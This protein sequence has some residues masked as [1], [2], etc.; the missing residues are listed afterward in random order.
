MSPTFASLRVPNYRRYFTG[1]LG[2]NTGTWMQRVA[3]DW[4]VL[5]LTGGNGTWLGIV[6]AL[7]FLRCRCSAWPAGLLADRL[8]KRRILAATNAFMG[9]TALVLG[10][11]TL[12]GVVR[13]WEVA[14]LAFAL[15]LGTALENPA[16]S[17]SCGD[18]RT[19]RT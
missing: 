3:Q 9:L 4:L 14:A 7:Q 19:H 13:V 2:S 6:T 12:T 1:M 15:G 8:P 10:A 5:Q 18:R 11:L 16:G 17:P